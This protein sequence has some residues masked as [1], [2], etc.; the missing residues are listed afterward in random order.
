M[1]SD[2]IY[3]PRKLDLEIAF[4]ALDDVIQWLGYRT[5]YD[6]N[7]ACEHRPGEV[8]QRLALAQ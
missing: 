4:S 5:D 7:D 3:E 2:G 1:D 8:K 6:Y